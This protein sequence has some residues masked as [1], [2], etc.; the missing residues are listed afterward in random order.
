M[1][2]AV[3]NQLHVQLEESQQVRTHV[4]LTVKLVIDTKYAL[5]F[6]QHLLEYVSFVL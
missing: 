5:L 6:Y 3:Q 4:F 2:Q 1:T